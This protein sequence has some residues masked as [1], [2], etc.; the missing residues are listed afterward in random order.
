M[1]I[2]GTKEQEA[3]WE[4]IENT[5][6]HIFVNAGAGTGKTFTIVEGAN[7]LPF[8]TTAAFLAFNKSI[9]TELQERLPDDVDAKTFHSFG[10]AAIRKAGIKTKYNSYKLNNI[11]KDL[12]GKDFWVSPVKKLVGLVKG[13]LVSA[14]DKHALLALIEQLGYFMNHLQPVIEKSASF[15]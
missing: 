12:L 4:A 11:I 1:K 15:P 2:T 8:G 7:R 14:T 5:D 9:A 10:F 13:S 6:E 3:I